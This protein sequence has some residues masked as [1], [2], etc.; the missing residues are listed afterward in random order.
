[1]KP[2][3]EKCSRRFVVCCQDFSLNLL[4]QLSDRSEGGPT[5]VR[6]ALTCSALSSFPSLATKTLGRLIW[7][8]K[9][10][11]FCNELRWDLDRRWLLV[12]G[13][14]WIC[15]PWYFG[16]PNVFWGGGLS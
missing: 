13:H 2:F 12:P 16:V 15:L 3:E 8:D 10:I 7:V 14:C 5:N 4:A 9:N 11:P 6:G 1:V